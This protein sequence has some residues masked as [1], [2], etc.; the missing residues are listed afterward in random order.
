MGTIKIKNLSIQSDW[1]AVMR[2]ALWMRDDVY[3]ACYDD[4]T[5][6]VDVRKRGNTYTVTDAEEGE[7][8]L[9]SY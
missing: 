6:T 3:D 1:S 2:V 7:R 4:G 8:C 5:K 9:K